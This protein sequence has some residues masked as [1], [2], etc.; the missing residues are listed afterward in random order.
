MAMSVM[1]KRQARPKESETITGT[2]TPRCFFQGLA[3]LC[4]TPVRVHGQETDRVSA[5]DVGGVH[6]GV[7]AD[8]A[9]A[10][11]GD[12][13]AAVHAHDAAALAEDNLDL[14]RVLPPPG[15]VLFSKRGGLD[16]PKIHEAPFGL[17]HDLVRH[18]EHVPGPQGAPDGPDDHLGQ[19]VTGAD[20]G[21][22]LDGY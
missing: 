21:E 20:L 16:G 18:H 19:P 15:R 3:E 9:V 17:A 1:P 13:D 4:G 10:G 14:A 12:D 2:S 7:G 22:A 11:L 8:E 5:G 6:A